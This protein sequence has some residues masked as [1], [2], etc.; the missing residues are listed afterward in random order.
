MVNSARRAKRRRLAQEAQWREGSRSAHQMDPADLSGP[1]MDQ[2]GNE[3]HE[4][5][6]REGRGTITGAEN[7]TLQY[8]D[9]YHG[10]NTEWGDSHRLSGYSSNPESI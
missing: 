9:H 8:R 6:G 3:D 1:G 2:E 4:I 10:Q 5:L 7:S